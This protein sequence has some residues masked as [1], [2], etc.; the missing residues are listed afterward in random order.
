[1][2]ANVES[3]RV[4]AK[5]GYPLAATRFVPASPNGQCVIINSATAVRQKY[6]GNFAR[7]LSQQGFTALTY[8]YRGIGNSLNSPIQDFEGTMMDWGTK[9]FAGVLAAAQTM[10]FNRILVAGHSAG[11]QLLGLAENNALVDA[12]LTVG[13]QSGYW[14]LW[15]GP[16]RYALAA[17]WYALM[18]G[19]SAV[20]SYF[21]ARRLGLG[22][23]LPAG[24]AN[25]WARWCRSENFIVDDEGHAVRQHFE[26][27]ARPV[28]AFSFADDLMAPKAA[29]DALSAFYSGAKLERRHLQP[30]HVGARR[31]GH[32]GFFRP[33]F[34]ATLWRQ[35]VAWLLAQ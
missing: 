17:L 34:E 35:S 20:L 21:P 1:M 6:Y 12:A 29:V 9:D 8:D 31:I 15:S 11:G 25:Q 7:Y 32:F 5:D 19:L 13:A 14:R 3:I 10:G 16:Q 24:I 2:H 27:F 18:P 26:S 23:N 30:A 33:E 22:E 4:L 28:L